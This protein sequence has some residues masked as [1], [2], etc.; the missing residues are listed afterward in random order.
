MNIN[1]RISISKD[2]DRVVA[3]SHSNTVFFLLRDQ[4]CSSLKFEEWEEDMET[5]LPWPVEF[6][7]ANSLIRV[8]GG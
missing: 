8:Q 2:I 4:R 3:D 5:S 1:M 7:S 6:S